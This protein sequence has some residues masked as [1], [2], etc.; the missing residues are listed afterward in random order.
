VTG[1]RS[2]DPSWLGVR[3]LEETDEEFIKEQIG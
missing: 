1:E 3:E 2:S